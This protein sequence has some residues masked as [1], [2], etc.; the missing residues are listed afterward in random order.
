MAHAKSLM[1]LFVVLMCGVAIADDEN[2]RLGFDGELVDYPAWIG[3]APKIAPRFIT[4]GAVSKTCKGIRIVSVDHR[5]IASRMGLERGDIILTV[6]KQAFSDWEG[7]RWA[8]RTSDQNVEILTLDCR[9]RGQAAL[10]RTIVRVPHRKRDRDLRD[11]FNMKF[12]DII[13]D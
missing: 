13:G 2:P 1:C 11:R 8:L 4:P 5:S 9:K 12:W 10:T 3:G 7:Y 6:D